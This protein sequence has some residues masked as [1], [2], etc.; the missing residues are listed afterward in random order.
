MDLSL[1]L[2]GDPVGR[3]EADLLRAE[4]DIPIEELVA[5]YGDGMTS[6]P[7]RKFKKDE[8]FLSPMIRPKRAT[9]GA[10]IS[11]EDNVNNS[12]SCDKN[13]NASASCS[14]LADSLVTR[15]ED[16]L[17]NGHADNENNLNTEKELREAESVNSDKTE[18]M[19]TDNDATQK[20]MKGDVDNCVP[21]SS[22]LSNNVQNVNSN[23]SEDKN[24]SSIDSSEADS[25]SVNDLKDTSANDESCKEKISEE[26]DESKP[27]CSSDEPS[28]SGSQVRLQN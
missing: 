12:N 14:G 5:K 6:I 16:K 8:K 3:T 15:L 18:D 21:D 13:D 10:K 25:T 9:E 23:K 17:A 26:V 1:F 28:G 11:N 20:S 27:S 24:S 19:E 4:A 7:A 22:E 2:D